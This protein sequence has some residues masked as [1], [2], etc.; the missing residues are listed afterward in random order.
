MKLKIPFL[1]P[2]RLRAPTG[3]DTVVGPGVTATGA[4]DLGPTG[5]GRVDGAL[6]ATGVTGGPESQLVVTGSLTPDEAA[7]TTPTVTVG[8]LRVLGEGDVSVGAVRARVVEVGPKAR[9][10]ASSVQCEVFIAAEGAWVNAAVRCATRE[11]PAVNPN[12]D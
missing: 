8:A 9:L 7:A 11:Q 6:R 2:R 5:V 10:E 3:F 4:L 12:P 1:G